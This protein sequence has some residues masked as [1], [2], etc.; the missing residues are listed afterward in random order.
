MKRNIPITGRL[1]CILIALAFAWGCGEQPDTARKPQ[2][3]RK[4]ITVAAKPSSKAR[5]KPS[6]PIA[7]KA[8]APSPKSDIAK[9]KPPRSETDLSVAAAGK[10][11]AVSRKGL[12]PKSDI[13]NQPLPATS[14]RK[15]A[16]KSGSRVAQKG[17]ASAL[18]ASA[19][20]NAAPAPRS[21]PSTDKPAAGTAAGKK[22]APEKKPTGKD[23]QA[24]KKEPADKKKPA[25]KK[26]GAP[27]VYDPTGRT[28]PFTPLFQEKPAP[29]AKPKIKKRVPRT[30][31]EKIALSQLK[32][33]AIILAPSGNRALVKEASGKGYVIRNGTYI[34]LDGGKVVDIEK[35]RV[36]IE[37]E[38]EDIL[39]KLTKRKKELKLAKPVGER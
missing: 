15:V 22:A 12:R 11:T 16:Q 33:T 18:P 9:T 24:E 38:I 1:A 26:K 25:A 32:L 13:A 29:V 3:V 28:D 6:R 7:G 5:K 39:G 37:E 2:V 27:S 35:S 31:L 8:T 17:D 34:G 4:K 10:G 21:E 20:V 23:K 36:V 30:P 14:P 19:S